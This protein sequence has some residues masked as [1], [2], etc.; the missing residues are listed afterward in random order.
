L[1]WHLQEEDN[2]HRGEDSKKWEGGNSQNTRGYIQA[3]EDRIFVD[4]VKH[5]TADLYELRDRNSKNEREEKRI[6]RGNCV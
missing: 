3:V 2:R 6:K 1:R 4:E 5:S